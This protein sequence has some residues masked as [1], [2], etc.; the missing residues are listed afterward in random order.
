MTWRAYSRCLR[1][2]RSFHPRPAASLTR[3]AVPSPHSGSAH[4]P[5]G[6]CH[7]VSIVSGNLKRLNFS[8]PVPI[9]DLWSCA[10]AVRRWPVGQ[11]ARRG[12]RPPSARCSPHPDPAGVGPG[13]PRAGAAAGSVADDSS[14]DENTGGGR[15]QRRVGAFDR[16]P[17]APS[18]PSAPSPRF[19]APRAPRYTLVWSGA[20]PGRPPLRPRVVGLPQG[21]DVGR[22]RAAGSDTLNPSPHRPKRRAPPPG[23]PRAV[24]AGRNGPTRCCESRVTQDWKLRAP[25]PHP[26]DYSSSSRPF[27]C[28]HRSCDKCN[29]S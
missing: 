5:Q 7:H 19:S 15:G 10:I 26:R 16:R 9:C 24:V 25:P 22:C 17:A 21:G 14:R 4:R 2:A 12:R 1:G 8:E 20:A 11:I 3:R 6:F 29:K 18:A 27:P 13:L 28:R 23:R